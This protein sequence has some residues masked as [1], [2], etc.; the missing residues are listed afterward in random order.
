MLG[1]AARPRLGVIPVALGRRAEVRMRPTLVLLTLLPCLACLPTLDDDGFA[2]DDSVD[3]DTVDDDDVTPVDACEVI[4]D[5]AVGFDAWG[6]PPE[7]E[8]IGGELTWDG[9]MLSVTQGKGPTLAVQLWYSDAV[10]I[11]EL[12]VGVSGP[13]RLF[14]SMDG[15]GSWAAWG[16]LAA[17]TDD[18]WVVVIGY[19]AGPPPSFDGAGFSL[20]VQPEAGVCPEPLVDV[21]GC[22][23]GSALPLAVAFEDGSTGIASEVW[24]EWEVS[25]TEELLFR[26]YVG[27]Q[28]EET[29]CLDFDT[30]AW[31]WTLHGRRVVR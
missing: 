19:N 11:D 12:M 8:W 14:R 28:V 20:D 29:T 4:G 5:D 23:L 7:G 30:S 15:S 31:S 22:G 13:G 10:P 2:D 17:V 16:V 25:L 3:D 21:Y 1:L 24:P 27:Y 18:G 26:Q 9:S 6:A